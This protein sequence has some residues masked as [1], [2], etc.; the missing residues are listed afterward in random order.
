MMKALE[1]EFKE[2]IK[3]IYPDVTGKSEWNLS[4]SPPRDVVDVDVVK[5]ES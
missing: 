2:V 5:F 3:V 4:S 1:H